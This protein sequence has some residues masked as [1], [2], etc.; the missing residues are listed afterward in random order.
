[1]H[2]DADRV[3]EIVE[4]CLQ[5]IRDDFGEHTERYYTE[6][7]V[8]CNFYL[9]LRTEFS[10]DCSK[11]IREA[12]PSVIHMEF[13]T[14]FRCNMKGGNFAMAKDDERTGGGKKYKRGHFDVVVFNPASIARFNE[15]LLRSQNYESYQSEIAPRLNEDD[16]LILYGIE[17]G[18]DREPLTMNGARR[19]N[20][21]AIQDHDKLNEAMK[22]PG[23]MK[24][25]RTMTFAK[26]RSKKEKQVL[27][28]LNDRE[29]IELV[30]FS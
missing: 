29:G 25:R 1:M 15:Q 20:K 10:E 2:P 24:K 9:Q 23:F 16:P 5:K 3:T 22:I 17:F 19:C 12:G 21:K 28:E 14:P 26:P 7:D 13:P 11:S 18:Y 30:M 8:V 27:L 4:I 6:N